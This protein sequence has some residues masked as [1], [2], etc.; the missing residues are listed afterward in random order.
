MSAT[1]LFERSIPSRDHLGPF[2]APVALSAVVAGVALD[3]GIRG[4]VTNAVLA[5]GLLVVIGLVFASR[6][7]ERVEGQCLAAFAVVPA[8]FLVIRASPWL[9]VANL[10]AFGGLV[11]AS[12]L[13]ARSG[14]VLDTSV[15]RL[16]RRTGQACLRALRL[17]LTLSPI[18]SGRRGSPLVATVWRIGRAGLVAFPLLALVVAF[19]AS[20]DA[21]FA[22]L[23]VPDVT[24]GP[25]FGHVL[26]VGLFTLGALFTIAAAGVDTDDDVAPGRFGTVEVLTML[27]LAA[28]VVGLFVISQLVALT[29]TGERLLASSG[30]TPAEYARSGFFQLC[31]ATAVLIAFLGLVRALA[32][33]GV[34][35]QLGVRLLA[36]WVPFL[37]LG[38]VT[39]CLRRMALYDQA[40]GLT[41]LRLAVVAVTIWLGVLLILIAVRNLRPGNDP[42]WVLGASAATALALILC[43]DLLNPEAFIVR[44]NLD[45]AT[46]GAELDALYLARLSDDALPAVAD[47]LG[48]PLQVSAN[49]QLE[50][51]LRCELDRIGVARLNL[52]VARAGADRSRV[53]AE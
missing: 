43:A 29:A 23:L 38:L 36:G 10:G 7:V 48:D 17:P 8:L 4:E 5:T 49:P 31:W 27:V 18:V 14:S 40:F 51:A 32:A 22:R 25:V 47:A 20:G 16:L 1:E 52:A 15:R 24:P 9:A 46:S 39:V 28:G 6:R 21:V 42:S 53:C 41:M 34:M 45:R 37:A 33:P 12:V 35:G 30:L 11:G 50:V 13:Y 44:H 3:L 26:L 2:P 19:L